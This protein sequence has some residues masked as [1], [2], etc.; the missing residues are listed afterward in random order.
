MCMMLSYMCDMAKVES[1]VSWHVWLLK[2]GTPQ[3]K[4]GGQVQC[5]M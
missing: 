1:N 5:H 2:H 3:I 4:E